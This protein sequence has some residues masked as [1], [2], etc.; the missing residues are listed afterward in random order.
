MS[1][2]SNLYQILFQGEMLFQVDE[3]ARLKKNEQVPLPVVE[4]PQQEQPPLTA[5]S[6]APQMEVKVP[7]VPGHF[8]ALLHQVLVL[9]DNPRKEFLEGDQRI[10]LDNILKA[11]GLGINQVDIVNVSFL[12]YRDATEVLAKRKINHLITFGVPL[13]KLK[14]DLLLPPYQPEKIEGIWL[15]LADNLA[16]IEGDKEIKRRLWMALKTMFN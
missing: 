6:P 4:V 10:L 13:I 8:P 7:E 14:I 2:E 12:D 5:S 9:I 3:T 1:R 15:L 16:T 11:I